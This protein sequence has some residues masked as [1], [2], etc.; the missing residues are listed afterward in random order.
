MS[1]E[2]I[3]QQAQRAAEVADQVALQDL[4]ASRSH[5]ERLRKVGLA[6]TRSGLPTIAC[7]LASDL[8]S[9]AI[10]L[11]TVRLILAATGLAPTFTQFG[12]RLAIGFTLVTLILHWYQGLYSS[13]SV[14]PAVE[15]RQVWSTAVGL[16]AFFLAL[17]WMIELPRMSLL[18][19]LALSA[20]A[21]AVVMPALRAGCR[22]AFGRSLWWGR[23]VLLVG[24]GEKSPELYQS[25][26]K[27]AIFGLRP[28]GYVEDFDQL[29]EDADADGYLGPIAELVERIED[30]Q[31]TLGLV[32]SNG[33][34]PRGELAHLVSRPNTGIE[35]WLV[36][37]DCVGLPC[38]WTSAREVAGMPA[39][40][41]SNRLRCPWRRSLKR[42]F[43]IA[44]VVAVSPVVLPL[45]GIVAL[46]IKLSSPGASPFFASD[47]IGKDGKRFS[48]WKLRTMVPH[49]E[50]VLKDYLAKHPTLQEEYERD[51]K[52]KKDPRV[53]WLGTFVRKASLDELPQLWNILVGEM[54][55]VGPRPMLTN[56]L[57]KYGETYEEYRLVTPGITGMWQISGRNNT[58]YRERLA[59]TD[60]YVKNWS[61]FLDIYILLATIKVVIFREGA[62]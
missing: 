3:A 44:I 24:C 15:L 14:R 18:A 49:A 37:S 12:I 35:D 34:G 46:L 21:T 41:L 4:V 43:D 13:I 10:S 60:Y 39:L 33:A 9:I 59:Y 17:Q 6:G 28:V 58:S 56:E 47:R 23:R 57:E 26:R 27:A 19:W 25:L 52:L 42:A 29:P 51:H 1:T 8:L 38:L 50:T 53:L 22:I 61:L 40:G 30:C 45:I 20:L 11:A 36:V 16:A 54:S 7:Y 5:L 62:Y 55:V 48:M 32:A 31:V 2:T